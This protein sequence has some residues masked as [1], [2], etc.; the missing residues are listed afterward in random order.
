MFVN[1]FFYTVLFELYPLDATVL[2]W[3]PLKNTEAQ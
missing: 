1:L 3:F 2:E